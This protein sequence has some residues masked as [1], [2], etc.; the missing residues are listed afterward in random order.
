[1]AL[2]VSY[3]NDILDSSMGGKRRYRMTTNTD[4]TVSFDDTTTYTQVGST[5]GAADLN[6]TNAE[7]N[8][9][10]KIVVSDTQPTDTSVLWIKPETT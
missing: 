6:A 5:I 7:V 10:V 2:S 1:M 3:K 4:G 8:G 9:L